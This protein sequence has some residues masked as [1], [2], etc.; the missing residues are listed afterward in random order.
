MFCME[1]IM[2]LEDK[3]RIL[4]DSAKYD[5]SC[6]SSGSFR[7]NKK[8]GLG[9][10]NA[11]GI[12]H[13]WSKDG[14]C[15]SLLKILLTNI[16]IYDCDFC[17]NRTSND[18]KRAIFTPQEI[19]NLTLD[20][21]KRNYIEGLFLSSGIVKNE[22]YTM[23]LLI[24]V[25]KKLR[26]EENFNGYIHMKAIPG[27][28]KRLLD[29]LGALV[30]RLS[31]NIEMPTDK[32]LSLYC[33]DKNEDN[34][35]NSMKRIQ[36]KI[37]EC[38][39]D[40]EKYKFAPSFTPAGQT[41]QMIIGAGEEADLSILKRAELLYTSMHLKRVYYSAFIPVSSS[42][43]LKNVS[44]APL[45]REHRI[46]QADFLMRYYD[47]KADDLLSTNR[48]NFDQNLDPKAFWAIQHFEIFPIEINTASYKDLLRVPGLG[49]TSAKRICSIRKMAHLS[50][51]SLKK[52]GIV[53]NR[54]K[55]FITVNGRYYG[56]TTSRKRIIERISDTPKHEQLSFL[57]E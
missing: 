37:V 16:C 5:V 32:S 28:S 20:F 22:N 47:F 25:A 23:E 7:K 45:K 30:D 19:V 34:I 44:S 38:K 49:P 51:E 8:N 52:T 11:S 17:V 2:L 24:E 39:E 3:I 29:Q 41:T 46:Y 9:S 43:L 48:Q 50:Y 31:I 33:P 21:Y 42:R 4:T 55:Y 12:C 36:E 10:A 14:R 6:S 13:S 56:E 54:A 18:R 26:K 35:L 53:L 57:G 40:R 15:I 1:A 27:S